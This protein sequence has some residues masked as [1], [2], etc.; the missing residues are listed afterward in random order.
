[1]FLCQEKDLRAGGWVSCS[2]DGAPPNALA[3]GKGLSLGLVQGQ[4]SLPLVS[5]VRWARLHSEGLGKIPGAPVETG[6]QCRLRGERPV[7]KSTDFLPSHCG[8]VRGGGRRA[9]LLGHTAAPEFP[10]GHRERGPGGVCPHGCPGSAQLTACE[11]CP[12]PGSPGQPGSVHV[13]LC[14]YLVVTCC[15]GLLELRP[16]K[17]WL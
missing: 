13:V 6:A 11:A 7:P 1:M 8:R 16:A 9:R 5:A 17:K 2:R 15:K 10:E 4:A 12:Q 14:L 3:P